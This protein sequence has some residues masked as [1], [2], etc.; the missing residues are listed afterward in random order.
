MYRIASQS[1][2]NNVDRQP[3][4]ALS[5]LLDDVKRLKSKEETLNISNT[6]NAC[7]S[8]YTLNGSSEFVGSGSFVTMGNDLTKGY[9]L[10][11]AHCVLKNNSYI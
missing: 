8:I 7:S 3:Q 1:F 4:I 11:A 9:F 10:T 5:G 6:E 2:L